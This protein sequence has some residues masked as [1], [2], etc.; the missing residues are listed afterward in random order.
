MMRLME[1][2]LHGGSQLVGWR[3]AQIHESIRAAL[4]LTAKQYNPTPL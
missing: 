1:V 4:G 3:T 2:L